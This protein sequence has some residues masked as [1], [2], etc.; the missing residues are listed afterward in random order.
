[1]INSNLSLADALFPD[2]HLS[3]EELIV[4]YPKRNASVVTRFAPSPTGFLHIG[5]VSSALLAERIAHQNNG[6]FF[7]RTEDTDMKRELE[8]AV[9]VMIS[10]LKQF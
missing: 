6:I 4:K 5:G 9:E 3:P 10:G 2:I 1:M 7:Y 8:G